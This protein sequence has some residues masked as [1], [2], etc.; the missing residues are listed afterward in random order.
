MNATRAKGLLSV[1]IEDKSALH[2]AYMPFLTGGGLFIPNSEE[3]AFGDEVFVL[4]RLEQGNGVPLAGRV[5]W[6]TPNGAGNGR[7]A[8]I[9]VQFSG[10]D[11]EVRRTIERS[12]ASFE[13]ALSQRDTYTL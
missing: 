11:D 9:G 6:I 12:L 1:T 13:P 4:L 2:A 7:P 10:R 8:G 5:V 3:F